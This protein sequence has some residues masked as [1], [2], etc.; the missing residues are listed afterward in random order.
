MGYDYVLMADE[1]DMISPVA[2]KLAER[3]FS[4][5]MRLDVL[6]PAERTVFLLYCLDAGVC[7]GGFVSFIYNPFGHWCVEAVEALCD[8]GA[9]WIADPFRE[10][11]RMF[12]GGRPPLDINARND[13][14]EELPERADLLL[15]EADETF[16]A[17]RDVFLGL[18][19]DY[20]KRHAA[21]A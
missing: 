10:V 7:N 15:K 1:L 2:T 6:T 21:G 4:A 3:V 8:V 12:P 17:N 13:A 5:D 9:E 14:L 18:L 20:V 16:F 11:L 19:S